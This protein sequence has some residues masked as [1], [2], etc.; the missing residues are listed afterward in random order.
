MAASRSPW[1]RFVGYLKL[2]TGK[3]LAHLFLATFVIQVLGV[4]PPL[5][6]QN[7]LDGVVVHQ[8]VSLLELLIAGLIVSNVFFT[9][10]GD[11]SRVP[12]E[13]HG[14]QHGLRDD[15]A[16]LQAYDVAAVFLLRQPQDRRYLRALSGEPDDSRV[17]DG[18]D[19]DDCAELC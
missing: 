11:Y 6:I 10:H 5:I 12:G 3:F 4:I 1:I 16:V 14:A 15:V 19:G 9:A 17:P 13:L 18:I 2:R 8:N 7:I